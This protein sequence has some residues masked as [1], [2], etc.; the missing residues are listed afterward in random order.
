MGIAL[1]RKAQKN[2]GARESVARRRISQRRILARAECKN[3]ITMEGVSMADE[4]K[5]NTGCATV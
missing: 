1:Q 4:G 2:S 3:R 5:K